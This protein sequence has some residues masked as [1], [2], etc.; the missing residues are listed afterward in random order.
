MVKVKPFCLLHQLSQCASHRTDRARWSLSIFFL[1]TDDFFPTCLSVKCCLMVLYWVLWLHVESP[2]FLWSAAW[3][4]LTA[5][6]V[7]RN[8]SE[9]HHRHMFVF[10]VVTSAQ[11]HAMCYTVHGLLWL[12]AMDIISATL[13]WC[14]SSE[15]SRSCMKIVC[16]TCMKHIHQPAFKHLSQMLQSCN[17]FNTLLSALLMIQS[18]DFP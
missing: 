2:A 13:N 5:F 10:K 16:F 9:H 14:C 1:V 12:K 17:E 11:L 15:H 4:R 6:Q 8:R 18:R 3:A 7:R